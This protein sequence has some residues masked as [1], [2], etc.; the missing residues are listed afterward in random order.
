MPEE[1][2]LR[3]VGDIDIA[4]VPELRRAWLAAID[5]HQPMRLTIDLS[6][7][8]FIDS[9][10]LELIVS[11]HTRQMERGGVVI[12]TNPSPMTARLLALTAIDQVVDVTRRP[13]WTRDFGR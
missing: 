9:M 6:E 4:T 3:P 1:Y 8:T 10:G 13:P 11:T 7:A 12:L 2:T 5:E